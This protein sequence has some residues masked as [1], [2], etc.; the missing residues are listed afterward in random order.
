MEDIIYSTKY[1]LLSAKD[2][3]ALNEAI[4]KAK[5]YPDDTNTVRYAPLEPFVDIDS[6][7]VMEITTDLQE[8][9]PEVLEGIKLVESY[10]PKS[11]E[12]L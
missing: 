4:S 6:N 10:T 11:T 7:C 5:G 9:Y 3:Q 8:N 1:A 12:E 2:Y